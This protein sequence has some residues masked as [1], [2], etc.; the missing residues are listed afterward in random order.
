[1]IK[2]Q[3]IIPESFSH[4]LAKLYRFGGLAM[5]EQEK[6]EQ[7]KEILVTSYQD[8]YTN[9]NVTLS[10]LLNKLTEKLKKLL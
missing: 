1:M 6:Q 3:R 2:L 5:S 9:N 10:E 7:F 4:Y 8:V